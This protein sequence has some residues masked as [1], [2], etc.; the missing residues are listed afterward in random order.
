MD[1]LDIFKDLPFFSRLSRRQL[2]GLLTLVIAL[3]ILPVAIYLVQRQVRYRSQAA[4]ENVYYVATNGNDSNPGTESQPWRTIQKAATTLKP[5]EKVYVRSGTYQEGIRPLLSGE[6]NNFITYSTYPGE[7]VILDLHD[8]TAI[9]IQDHNF[10][11]VEGFIIEANTQAAW[12]NA[13]NANHNILSN[14]VMRNASDRTHGITLKHSSY[15]QFINN[16]FETHGRD[17]ESLGGSGLDAMKLHEDCNYN[18][19]EGN[20]F[21]NGMHSLL[22]VAGG[23]HNIIRNNYFQ[24]DWYKDVD[25]GK[26]T[27]QNLWEGNV[28]A[29]SRDIIDSTGKKHNGS[30]I[31]FAS[32]NNIIRYNRFYNNPSGN[33]RMTIYGG[34]P[35][36]TDNH[37]NRVYNN[38]MY[39]GSD[40]DIPFLFNIAGN[41][42]NNIF[43]N[44]IITK[45]YHS[46][47]PF[48]IWFSGGPYDL[49]N[50]Q[51]FY[52]DIINQSPGEVVIG[53]A[54]KGN[55]PLSWWQTNYPANFADNV[56]ADPKF[57]NEQSRDFHLQAGSSLIDAGIYLTETEGSGSGTSL[58]VNDARYFFDGYGIVEPDWIKIGNQEPVQIS[59]VNYDTNII[60]FTQSRNWNANDPVYLYKNS[61]GEVVLYGSAPD[62]GAYEYTEGVPPTPTPTPSPSPSPL[63]SPSPSPSPSPLP[64]PIP[65]PIPSPSI[66]PIQSPSPSPSPSPTPTPTPTPTPSHVCYVEINMSKLSFWKWW[67]VRVEVRVV[68]WVTPIN[69]AIVEGHWN[70]AKTGSVSSRTDKYGRARFTTGWMR[71]GD[72]VWFTVDRLTKDGQEYILT[73]ELSDSIYR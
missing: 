7:E 35:S 30:G 17:P 20:H 71:A 54:G 34:D 5:G 58:H 38:V 28:F 3:Y 47:G 51:F 63:P 10:I 26:G 55:Y 24:N 53:H 27:Y 66:K 50:N 12:V 19:I 29:D 67:R 44:N 1:F 33:L 56:E 4:P 61:L 59:S 65:S 70:G 52:N 60:T 2:I 45:G 72:V 32:A 18:L 15:N 39:H 11:K 69:R 23:H 43:K 14:N 25:T 64:S 40:A 22:N 37:D 8:G 21:H 36:S 62:I 73:G 13:E 31:Q 42:S 41:M 6:A 48:Q 49:A 9:Y 57:V 68:E 16:T 46:G